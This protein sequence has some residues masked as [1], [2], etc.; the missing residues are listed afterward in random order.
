L[1]VDSVLTNAKA[2]LN[3]E[4]VDCSIAVENDE[5]FKI[6][7][8]T[9]MPNADEKT[10]LRNMLVLP[11]LIDVHVHLRDEGKT[12]KEDFYT[13]TAAAAA[14]G[15]TTVLDMPNNDP[16]T[17]S[18][19]TLKHRM[20]TAERSVLVNVG[21][22]SE[23]PNNLEAVPS[24]VAQGAVG[25]K[26]F[27]AH[28][29]G[30]LNI[31]DDEALREAFTKAGESGVPV[32]VHAEDKALLMS[33]EERLKRSKR[34]GAAA[35]LKA[36]S[37]LVE[38]K[39]VER[40]LKI[41][42]QTGV[43]LHFCHMSTEEGLNAVVEAKKSGRNVTCEVTPQHLLLSSAD[44]ERVGLMLTMMPPL[45]GAR[46]MEALWKGVADGWVDVLGSDHAPHALSEK[47]AES[48][49]DV[50]VGVPGLETTLPLMLTMVR[51]NKISLARV[52]Q[53]LSERPAEIFNLK[54]RGGLVQ[55]NRADLVVVDFN[56]K[57]RVD[58]SKFQSKAKFSP[59]DGWEVQGRPVKT[60]VNGLLVM[61]EQEIVAKP[62]SGEVIRGDR[63]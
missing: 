1:I 50:K 44:F 42:A 25:F 28:Q 20:R 2:Y 36:H 45:R 58:A 5:I 23:F 59:F 7:K 9:Q 39:A 22:Y 15:M 17:M 8:E 49:W 16:V 47:S 43:R 12:Y 38:L 46:H 26:L 61:D 51:K 37:D 33:S 56:R 14:G 52:V 60:F 31:D 57:F 63:A 62:G 30:G 4:I 55:G 13:G 53:L 21:F 40:L 10:N 29:V 6:G 34:N 48:V 32:A 27:M 3:R 24:L 41:S 11:G 35:F 54:R 18:T 19:Q